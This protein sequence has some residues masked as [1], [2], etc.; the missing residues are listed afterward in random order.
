MLPMGGGGGNDGGKGGG[1]G[2][3]LLILISEF[4]TFGWGKQKVPPATTGFPL[5][6]ATLPPQPPN[7][8]QPTATT[9]QPKTLRRR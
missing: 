4:I 7:L 6:A 9:T 3:G 1:G 2:G 8:S 5:L